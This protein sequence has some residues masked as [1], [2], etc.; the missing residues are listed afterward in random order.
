MSDFK[1]KES[2]IYNLIQDELNSQKAKP[3]QSAKAGLKAPLQ[4]QADPQQLLNKLTQTFDGGQKAEFF[5]VWEKLI[6][7]KVKDGNYDFKKLEFNLHIYFV[8]YVVHPYN[9]KNRVQ[10]QQPGL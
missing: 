6:P 5:T 7:K 1:G 10:Q 9:P 8:V 4:Q 2:L 3:Q